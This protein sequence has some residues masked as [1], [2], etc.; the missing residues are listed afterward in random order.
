M[1]Q[2][3]TILMMKLDD[4]MIIQAPRWEYRKFR[5]SEEFGV[6]GH[7]LF[8]RGS[9]N[10]LSYGLI[11]GTLSS[12]NLQTKCEAE[13]LTVCLSLCEA[14][15]ISHPVIF[16]PFA[17]L[18]QLPDQLNGRSGQHP[19]MKERTQKCEEILMDDGTFRSSNKSNCRLYKAFNNHRRAVKLFLHMATNAKSKV[20]D[21]SEDHNH[22]E[23]GGMQPYLGQI[24]TDAPFLGSSLLSSESSSLEF[25]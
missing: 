25:V 10:T 2:N 16:P 8:G 6:H 22:Q 12:V 17:M 7:V 1:I 15:S 9:A 19:L 20:V 21:M 5:D 11:P 23:T 3:T 13:V 4:T 14:P 24:L 18:R